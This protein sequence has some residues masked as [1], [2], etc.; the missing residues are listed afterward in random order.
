MQHSVR[1]IRHL[2][3]FIN[4]IIISGEYVISTLR[5]FNFA[6]LKVLIITDK[7]TIMKVLEND[8]PTLCRLEHSNAAILSSIVKPRKRAHSQKKLNFTIKST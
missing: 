4:L 3:T 1:Y 7:I 6:D 2:P 5:Q 8:K